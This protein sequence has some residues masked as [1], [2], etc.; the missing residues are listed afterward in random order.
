MYEDKFQFKVKIRN[1]LRPTNVIYII[2]TQHNIVNDLIKYLAD[3]SRDYSQHIYLWQ[4]KE[5]RKL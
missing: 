4:L 5:T 3:F 1:L 2:N